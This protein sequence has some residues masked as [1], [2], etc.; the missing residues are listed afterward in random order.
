MFMLDS[1]PG[2]GALSFG[3]DDVPLE[4]KF[5]AARGSLEEILQRSTSE[6][7]LLT[8]LL[9]RRLASSS[10]RR[11]GDP[12]FVA[13][14]TRERINA[15][16]VMSG[17]MADTIDALLVARTL[18]PVAEPERGRLL[19]AWVPFLE[20]AVDGEFAPNPAVHDPHMRSTSPAVRSLFESM[21]AYFRAGIYW[22]ERTGIPRR[23]IVQAQSRKRVQLAQ[24]IATRLR[25]FKPVWQTHLQRQPR[26]VHLTEET[27][28][29]AH[30][31]IAR[32]LKRHPQIRGIASTSW[33]YDPEIG[34]V[35]PRLGFLHE[36]LA[37]N[38]CFVFEIPCDDAM[39]GSALYGSRARQQA[40]ADG[41][42]RP[43]AF[44][45]LWG[46]DALLPWAERQSGWQ[47]EI[48]ISA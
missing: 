45:R 32:A 36:L 8:D 34:E 17:K 41:S 27:F 39:R 13:A 5:D 38:G 9:S 25:G 11:Q 15:T 12:A 48:A 10:F 21:R 22:I 31:E 43:R 40:Y 19:R 29:R 35:S 24:Y 33:Y 2:L 4:T 16:R 47:L 37:A 28:V 20:A 18:E 3:V 1:R 23:W 7:R 44:A 14:L 30:L 46:R 26:G 42:Y 6:A